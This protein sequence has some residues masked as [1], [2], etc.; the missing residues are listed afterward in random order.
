M[1]SLWLLYSRLIKVDN[2]FILSS[3]DAVVVG[4]VLAAVNVYQER[5]AVSYN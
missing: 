2:H 5:D 3:L 4:Q 1:Y